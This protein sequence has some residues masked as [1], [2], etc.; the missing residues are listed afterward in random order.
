M[1]RPMVL[2]QHVAASDAVQ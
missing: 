2:K 1:D